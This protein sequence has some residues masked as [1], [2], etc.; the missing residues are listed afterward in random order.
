MD[1]SVTSE[2]RKSARKPTACGTNRSMSKLK[3]LQ[4]ART[5]SDLA[6]LLGFAPNKFAFLLYKL[7]SEAKYHQFEIP[8]RGG[9][10]RRIKAPNDALALAQKRLADLL[11]ECM[12]EM[13]RSSPPRKSLAHGFERSR[14]ILTNAAEHRARRYVLN[15][16]L[17]D[18]FPSINFGRV[19]AFFIKDR[20]FN[21][22]PRVATAL[23]QLSCHENELPQGSPCSPPISNLIGHLLDVRLARLAKACKCHYSRYADDLT[24]STNQKSFPD[25]IAV[26]DERVSQNWHLAQP[27]IEKI[28]RAGFVV[29]EQKTRMQIRGSRQ[30]VTGLIVNEKVNVTR[31]YYLAAR[32][33]CHEYFRTGCYFRNQFLP[34]EKPDS[35]TTEK[36]KRERKTYSSSAPLSGILSHIYHIKNQSD[37]RSP[38]DKKKSPT[39]TRKLYFKFL[40][41]ENFI[42]TDKPVILTE[43]KTDAVYLKC[44]IRQLPAFHPRLGKLSDKQFS[45]TVRFL[46]YSHNTH[47]VLQLGGGSD[48]LKHFI[49]DYK[50][51][52]NMFE[53]KT[54][55]SPI[56]ILIDNDDGADGIFSIL[57]N[58]NLSINHN[59]QS[60]FYHIYENLYLVKTPENAMPVK[61]C[62]ED[63]FDPQL[64]A[65]RIGG[66][67]FNPNQ[68]E[69]SPT[70]YGKTVFAEKVVKPNAKTINF[71]RFV[72]LLDRLVAVLDHYGV[73]AALRSSKQ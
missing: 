66:K 52:F 30:I 21:L 31:E 10:T 34:Q 33:M 61:S 62:I 64:R 72:P 16:D 55:K 7:P 29:N 65:T 68:R 19:R 36:A 56:I 35:A 44:A 54:P 2:T 45:T 48:N 59:S 53:K 22:D 50:K 39:A 12:Q 15:A 8:K 37:K 17:K 40:F 11:Y 13:G 18:F 1:Y 27:L 58:F 38:S 4:D 23:A 25:Q 49:R 69:P 41:H 5:T 26:L 9:G 6:R 42:A 20:H 73:N 51:N 24:F 60:N 47:D 70:E 43:G 67:V 28:S 3:R 32:A 71:A 14:S 46:N 63:L 57:K